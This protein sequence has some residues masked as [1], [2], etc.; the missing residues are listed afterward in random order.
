MGIAKVHRPSLP[1]DRR[2]GWDYAIGS[3]GEY[4]HWYCRDLRAWIFNHRHS[5]LSSRR[6][7][8]IA[9]LQR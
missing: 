1:S 9:N 5:H 3:K 2:S 4:K 8:D 6:L 7:M